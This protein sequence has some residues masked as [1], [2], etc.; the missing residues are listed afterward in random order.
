V[1]EE[2]EIV[3]MIQLWL[4]LEDVLLDILYVGEEFLEVVM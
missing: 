1:Q 3:V 2:K 4:F